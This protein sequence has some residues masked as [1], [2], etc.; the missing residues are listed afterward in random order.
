MERYKGVSVLR[1]RQHG[2]DNRRSHP[3]HPP[4]DL[5]ELLQG[6]ALCLQQQSRG[7]SRARSDAVYAGRAWGRCTGLRRLHGQAT[8]QLG[9]LAIFSDTVLCVRSPGHIS[10]SQG[11]QR[12]FKSNVAP[13]SPIPEEGRAC[14]TKTR[15]VSK[16]NIK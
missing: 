13:R 11:L 15:W 7:I 3:S 8:D 10:Q 2:R 4:Y 5:R 1:A 16:S 9:G 12:Q 6:V 14:N